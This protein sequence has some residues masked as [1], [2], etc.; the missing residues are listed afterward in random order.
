MNLAHLRATI[1]RL[2]ESLP[3][4]SRLPPGFV[5]PVA[6]YLR[7]QIA[8]GEPPVQTTPEAAAKAKARVS[9]WL[10]RGAVIP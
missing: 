7:A 6:A 9:T 10:A 5:D 1:A 2:R 4:Q 3:A 8:R